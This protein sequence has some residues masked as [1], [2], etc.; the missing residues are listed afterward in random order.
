MDKDIS[1]LT[2][3]DLKKLHRIEPL[4]SIVVHVVQAKGK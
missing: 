3:E 1:L 4:N 2:Q